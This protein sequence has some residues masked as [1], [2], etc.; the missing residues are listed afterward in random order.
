[1]H[2]K[3]LLCYQYTPKFRTFKSLKLKINCPPK[4]LY[5]TKIYFKNKAEIKTFL[6]LKKLKISIGNSLE[7]K[8]ILQKTNNCLNKL[9]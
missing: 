2:T 3:Q 8:D 1:M 9:I 4:S 6:D 7:L 5:P